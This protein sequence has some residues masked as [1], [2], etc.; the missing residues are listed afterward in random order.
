MGYKCPDCIARDGGTV[1]DAGQPLAG[2]LGRAGGD[3]G[4]QSFRG[5]R[6]PATPGERLPFTL[7][8]RGT[9]AGVAAAMLGG[10]I[11][12]PVMLG[13]AFFLISSGVIGWG[14]ARSVYWATA[15]RNSP[16]LRA[17]ALTL[18]GFTVAIGLVAA[19]RTAAPAG[20]LLLAYPAAVY[21]GWIVVRQR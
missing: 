4:G 18:A 8:A 13:G 3:R 14:V 2:L 6:T 21:G 11:L 9:V 12:G 16:Y 5:T 10:L 20:M 1:P 19:G 15:E 17:V 7:G